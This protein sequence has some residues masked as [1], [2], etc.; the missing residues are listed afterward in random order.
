MEEPLHFHER[1][2]FVKFISGIPSPSL[3]ENI[4]MGY[5]ENA[6]KIE[7]HGE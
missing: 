6:F 2:K 3:R 5:I 1:N 4:A 7:F